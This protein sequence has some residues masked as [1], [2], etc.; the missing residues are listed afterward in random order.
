MD[1]FKHHTYNLYIMKTLS[2][3]DISTHLST[4]NGVQ[5]LTMVLVFDFILL[6]LIQVGALFFGLMSTLLSG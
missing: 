3:Y 2:L 4:S 5:F 1:I 6:M